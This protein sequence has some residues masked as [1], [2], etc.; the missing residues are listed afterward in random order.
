[1]WLD[2]K[3]STDLTD[4]DLRKDRK[5]DIRLDCA[6]TGCAL[7]SDAAVF[8]LLYGEPGATYETCRSALDGDRHDGHR[9]PLAAAAQGS[10]IC[11]RNRNG[12]IA[13]LVLTVKSTALPD[14]AFVTADRTVWRAA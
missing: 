7:E 13:L 3:T 2:G 1:M 12:D 5:G 11:V 9:L 14:I 10:E 8:K 6:G 4:M